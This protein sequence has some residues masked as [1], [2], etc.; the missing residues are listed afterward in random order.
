M[1]VK[2]KYANSQ[3]KQKLEIRNEKE[4]KKNDKPAYLTTTNITVPRSLAHPLDLCY[5]Q[6]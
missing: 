3:T 2:T 5:T 6:K 1:I 4:K